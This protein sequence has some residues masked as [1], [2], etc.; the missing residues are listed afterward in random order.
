MSENDEVRGG[1][2][3]SEDDGVGL[4]AGWRCQK[5]MG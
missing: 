1:S 4:G 2:R 3:L 5:L